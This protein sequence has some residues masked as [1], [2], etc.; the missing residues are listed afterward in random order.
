ME[1]FAKGCPIPE[2]YI[3][4]SFIGD[5]TYGISV[6]YK[7]KNGRVYSINIGK[8]INKLGD[9]ISFFDT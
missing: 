2:Q 6:P 9:V 8:E 4:N 5:K 3:F 1:N 7:Q